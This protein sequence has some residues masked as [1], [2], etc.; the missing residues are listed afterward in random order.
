MTTAKYDD[1]LCGASK[2]V[3]STSCKACSNRALGK[4]SAERMKATWAEKATKCG[5]C[6]VRL[7]NSRSQWC[8]DCWRTKE[9]PSRNIH[10]REALAVSRASRA[11]A[12]KSST[13]SKAEERAAE[14]LTVL[15]YTFERQVAIGSYVVDFLLPGNTIVEVYGYYH[16]SHNQ[17]HDL[18]KE[19]YLRERGFSLIV[20]WWDSEHLWW[21]KFMRAWQARSTTSA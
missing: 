3:S 1:C 8:K 5:H 21:Q 17:A 4:R 6:G 18:K 20:L 16:R 11:A 14:L 9:L 12:S 19:Q 13:G 7:R 2:L 10:Q 15:G